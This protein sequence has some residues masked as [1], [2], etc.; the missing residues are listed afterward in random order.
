MLQNKIALVTGGGRGIGRAISTSLATSGAKII[1]N[2]LNDEEAAQAT[3]KSIKGAGGAAELAQFDV[4][5]ETQVNSKIK[6]CLKRYGKIDILV[7]NAG[8]AENSIFVRTDKSAWERILTTNLHGSFYC[9]RA[10][11]KSMLKKCNG[12]II[13][14]S[15]I[16][17]ETGN[18]GQAPYAA[19]K[20]AAIGL[21]K[22]LAKELGGQGITVNAITPG[23][24]KTDM[25][26]A[27][28]E[29]QLSDIF[30]QIPVARLGTPEDIAHAVNFLAGPSAAYING[31]V[32]KINGGMH[33]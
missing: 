28:T 25:I 21:T 26:K 14:I 4:S 18:A 16:I 9:A 23:C 1:I 11:S 13:N 10:V 30:K 27:L 2:Y 15:S 24:I 33:I 12:R 19:A 31:H 32:L 17:G 20:S 22:S 3:A 8:I 29:A 5:N 6:D 7:N